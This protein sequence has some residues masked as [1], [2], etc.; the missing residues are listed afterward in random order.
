M[1]NTSCIIRDYEKTNLDHRRVKIFSQGF[2]PE[3]IWSNGKNSEL[4]Q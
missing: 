3:S 1:Q 2:E 4:K